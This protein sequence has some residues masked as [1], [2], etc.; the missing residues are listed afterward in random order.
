MNHVTPKRLSARAIPAILALG[1]AGPVCLVGQRAAAQVAVSAD[2]QVRATQQWEDVLLIEDFDYLQLTPQQVKEL[3]VLADYARSRMD[4]VDQL[5]ARLQKVLQDQHAAILKGQRPSAADQ[6]DVLQKQRLIQDRQ[7]Q[8]SREIVDR[9]TPK[10]GGILGRKQI[11]RAWQLMQNK[12]PAS[13]PKRVA[14]TEPASGFVFPQMEVRD[15]MEEMVKN[16]LRQKYSPEVLD[17]AL[18]PWEISSMASMFGGGGLR[19]P[20]GA[21]GAGGVPPDPARA[22]QA[23][24]D[25]DPRMMQRML[26]IGQKMLKQYTGGGGLDQAQPSGPPVPPEVR[27]AINKDA[28][29]LRKSIESDPAAYLSQAHD[30]QILE[31]LRPLARRLFLSPRL[32]EALAARAA[33]QL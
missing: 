12:L 2:P 26:T 9:V 24:Q 23:I 19:G 20:G 14:L 8:V 25:M 17:Q 22:I 33:R 30:S 31:A 3:Q 4:E 13:E 5:R 11:V 7:E 1:L 29:A 28:D 21:P 16:S 10:L 15:A 18:T 6:Q 32:K 27:A